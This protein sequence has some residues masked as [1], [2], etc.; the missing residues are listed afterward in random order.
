MRAEALLAEHV[1]APLAETMAALELELSGLDIVEVARA[2][3][4]PIEIVAAVYYA[5]DT[6]LNHGWL[7]QQIALLP[8]DNHWQSLARAA[9]RDELA[10]RQR[11]LAAAVL[12]GRPAQEAVE[13]MLAH[14]EQQNRPTLARARRVLADLQALPQTDLAMLSVAL[15]EL[16]GLM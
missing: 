11:S 3:V 2:A 13:P 10:W 8:T 9:L 14:W 5:L 15:R 6:R 16:R 7:R 12:H 4:R 1:P